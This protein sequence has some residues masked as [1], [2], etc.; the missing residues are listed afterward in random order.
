MEAYALVSETLWAHLLKSCPSG[1]DLQ[2]L[3]DLTTAL[4]VES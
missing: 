4:G 1:F 2:K 3:L